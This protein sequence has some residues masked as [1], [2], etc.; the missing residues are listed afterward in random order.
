MQDIQSHL[1]PIIST[2]ISAHIGSN[3]GFDKFVYE[4]GVIVGHLVHVFQIQKDQLQDV[5]RQQ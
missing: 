3:L 4:V 5:G 1:E 2:L